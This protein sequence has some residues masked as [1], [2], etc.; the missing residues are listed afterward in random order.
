M[1]GHC[2][3]LIMPCMLPNNENQIVP[4]QKSRTFLKV[5][6]SSLCPPARSRKEPSSSRGHQRKG[7]AAEAKKVFSAPTE[8]RALWLFLRSL[9]KGDL[10]QERLVRLQFLP[11]QKVEW[12][13]C[14][15]IRTSVVNWGI[16]YG[17]VGVGRHFRVIFNLLPSGSI[18]VEYKTNLEPKFTFWIHLARKMSLYLDFWKY[19]SFATYDVLF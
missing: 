2:Q 1:R 11:K 12:A 10:T 19:A 16:V 13:W 5:M 3:I 17:G 6:T 7:F 9:R 15:C 4:N 8:R 14:P 18:W